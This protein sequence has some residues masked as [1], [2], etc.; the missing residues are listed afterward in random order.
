MNYLYI[1]LIGV[2]VNYLMVRRE[3]KKGGLMLSFGI[4][5]YFIALSWVSLAI[6]TYRE[7]KERRLK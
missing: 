5:Y 3:R 7:I 1:Y 2:L 4:E 6:C